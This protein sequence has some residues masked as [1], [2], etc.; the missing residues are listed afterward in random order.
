MNKNRW[1]L[2]G[3]VALGWF[4]AGTVWLI[5]FSCYPLWRGVG[6][7]TF[8]AYF[9]FWQQGTRYVVTI[10][11]AVTVIGSLVLLVT[12]WSELPR[13]MLCIGVVLQAAIEFVRSFW[14]SPL[15]QH[16]ALLSGQPNYPA[17][18]R[19]I[20]ANWLLIALVT[21]YAVLALWIWSRTVWPVK[22]HTRARTL[23]F[24]NCALGLYAVGNIWLVQL[25]SYQ[26]WPHVGKQDAYAYHIAWWHSIWGVLFAPAG[27]VLLGSL[28]MLRI[29]PEGISLRTGRV[30]FALQALIYIVTGIWFAPLMARLATP[31][32]GLSVHL[33][34]LLMTTHWVRVGLFTA[35]GA[36]CCYMLVKSGSIVEC[37]NA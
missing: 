14:V 37:R 16:V 31:V 30:A 20:D 13:W 24:V 10:P 9:Q 27:V 15:E 22:N 8:G 4:N 23:L 18:W 2:L 28:A 3:L 35:Y 33:Y 1:L 7:D 26:L 34:H 32:G 29:R 21:T 36:M 6:G 11:F 5:Q 25:V 12:A 17:Y 19:L